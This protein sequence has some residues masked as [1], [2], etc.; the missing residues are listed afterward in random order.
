MHTS[1][2]VRIYLQI[3]KKSWVYTGRTGFCWSI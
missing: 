3:L 1:S 2:I